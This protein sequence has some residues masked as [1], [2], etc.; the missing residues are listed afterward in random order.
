MRPPQPPIDS[1]AWPRALALRWAREECS[2]GRR[3]RRRHPDRTR[4]CPRGLVPRGTRCRRDLHARLC[5]RRLGN[6]QTRRRRYGSCILWVISLLL[7]CLIITQRRSS[8]L[9]QSSIFFSVDF[10][11]AEGRQVT[12]TIHKH[13]TFSEPGMPFSNPSTQAVHVAVSLVSQNPCWPKS[14]LAAQK[15]GTA[16]DMITYT[17]SGLFPWVDS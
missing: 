15:V 17:S 8:P 3:R 4:F 13:F 16:A 14:F 2:I 1:L 9:A 6:A 12:R 5:L 7:V 10:F 11:P